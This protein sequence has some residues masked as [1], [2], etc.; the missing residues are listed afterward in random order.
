MESLS[1]KTR[2]FES[3]QQQLSG[4]PFFQEVSGAEMAYYM[5]NSEY[6]HNEMSRNPYSPGENGETQEIYNFMKAYRKL[7]WPDAQ[8]VN[9]FNNEKTNAPQEEQSI[10]ELQIYLDQLLENWQ[11][12]DQNIFNNFINKVRGKNLHVMG[13][14]K[15]IDFR[16]MSWCD[17]TDPFVYRMI[18][19]SS[20]NIYPERFCDF[21]E[22][23]TY[24]DYHRR[25]SPDS[26]DDLPEVDPATENF[27]Y[28]FCQSSRHWDSADED[29]D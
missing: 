16:T 6:M 29:E 24:Y 1:R 5:S 25:H 12:L 21:P 10:V 27:R 2:Y 18:V 26:Q 19:D 23:F 9:D 28:R 22:D 17:I 14:F 7:K 8:Y 11:E 13:M 15:A 20:D 3:S 4:C